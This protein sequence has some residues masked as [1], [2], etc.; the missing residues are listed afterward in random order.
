MVEGFA[1]VAGPEGAGGLD[2]DGEDTGIVR[3]L[4]QAGRGSPGREPVSESSDGLP[5]DREVLEMGLGLP[6]PALQFSDLRA[7]VKAARTLAGVDDK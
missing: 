7:E 1:D 6:Q 2:E 3:V 4:G 5:G